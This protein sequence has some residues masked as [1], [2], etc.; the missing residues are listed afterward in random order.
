[1]RVHRPKLGSGA[2]SQNSRICVPSQCFHED[3]I[4][5]GQHDTL[6]QTALNRATAK[7]RKAPSVRRQAR[8][9]AAAQHR[10]TTKQQPSRALKVI[11]PLAG[12]SV[13]QGWKV[14]S[15]LSRPTKNRTA[16]PPSSEVAPRVRRICSHAELLAR[17]L[18]VVVVALLAIRPAK[19]YDFWRASG[20][21]SHKTG[22]TLDPPPDPGYRAAPCAT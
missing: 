5:P 6:C 15:K 9:A 22:V 12:R 17:G 20:E 13:F 1:M 14:Q 10:F 19:S 11:S 2:W 18:T 4:P 8:K 21:R 16:Q 3:A 7:T